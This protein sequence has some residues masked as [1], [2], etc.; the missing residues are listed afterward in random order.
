MEQPV[1]TIPITHHVQE[2]LVDAFRHTVRD[3]LQRAH[4][5]STDM[6]RDRDARVR[7]QSKLEYG[8]EKLDLKRV[9]A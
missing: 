8:L 9:S 3:F 5:G 7:I 2:H 4:S 1:R 6:S